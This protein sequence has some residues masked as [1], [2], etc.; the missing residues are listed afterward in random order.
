M[1]RVRTSINPYIVAGIGQRGK[2]IRVQRA[3]EIAVINVL[4]QIIILHQ[5]RL[6]TLHIPVINLIIA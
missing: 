1:V 3:T 2:Q 4:D 5:K 6:E